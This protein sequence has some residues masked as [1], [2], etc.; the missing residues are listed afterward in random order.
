[1]VETRPLTR[2][3]KGHGLDHLEV[4]YVSKKNRESE[5]CIMWVLRKIQRCLLLSLNC[6]RYTSQAYLRHNILL[7][8][9]GS[10]DHW[11]FKK[12]AE[13]KWVFLWV[14]S[15]RKLWSYFTNPTEI[16]GN[17]VPTL[18]RPLSEFASVTG[19]PPR[20]FYDHMAW[21]IPGNNWWKSSSWN[22][23]QW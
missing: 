23:L 17:F 19:H 12:M 7:I 1:M 10:S 8:A 13:N 6:G 3:S 14:F 4:I 11:K 5:A 2:E 16:P 15:P 22:D 18:N 20:G 9:D 21:N